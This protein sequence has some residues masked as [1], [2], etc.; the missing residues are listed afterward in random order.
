MYFA[1][2]GNGGD[3]LASVA[4][5]IL[6]DDEQFVDTLS[7]AGQA[8]GVVAAFMRISTEAKYPIDP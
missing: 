5:G 4:N 6:D 8:A 3:L 7:T 1:F 2:N